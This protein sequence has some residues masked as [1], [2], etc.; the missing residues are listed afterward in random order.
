MKVSEYR[1]Q[2][3]ERVAVIEAQVI[4][5]YH[6]IKE[7]KELVKEQNGRVRTNEQNIARI[8]AVGIVIAMVLG[9]L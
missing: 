7:I 8:T 6:D 3:A 2:M 1:E 9:L 5:I 4:D